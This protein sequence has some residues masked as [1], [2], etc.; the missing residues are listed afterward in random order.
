[1]LSRIKLGVITIKDELITATDF[2]RK[3]KKSGAW[4]QWIA[5]KASEKGIPYP[6]KVGNYWLASPEQWE[7]VLRKLNIK[8]RKRKKTKS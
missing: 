4:G 6:K 8:M 1:M 7:E 2:A 3:M 5:K